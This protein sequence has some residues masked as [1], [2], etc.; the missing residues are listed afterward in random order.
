MILGGERKK[1]G[2]D[3]MNK[4]LHNKRLLNL[5]QKI[6][7]WKAVFLKKQAENTDVL[8]ETFAGLLDRVI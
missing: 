2:N 7:S 4:I 1:K 6:K 8:D 5:P 3:F